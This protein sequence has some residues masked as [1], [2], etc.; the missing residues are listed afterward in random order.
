MKIKNILLL[1]SL[2]LL[3]SCKAYER[4]DILKKEDESTTVH[5]EKKQVLE[6]NAFT[7]KL[8]KQ[9]SSNLPSQQNMM[10][11]PFSISMALSMVSNGSDGETLKAFKNTLAFN[12]IPENDINAHH[13]GLLK[14]IVKSDDVA[15]LNIA[16]SIWLNNQFSPLPSFIRTNIDYYNATIANLNFSDPT[17]KDAINNWVKRQTNNKIPV[18]LSEL[19]THNVMYLI[20]AVY[21][22]SDWKFKFDLAFTKNAAFTISENNQ[23]SVPFMKGQGEFKTASNELVDAYE[24]PFKADRFSMII[25]LPKT[26]QSV[27]SVMDKLS[28]SQLVALN[29]GLKN[30]NGLLFIPKFKFSY[31]ADLVKNLKELGL[32][33]AFTDVANFSR[34]TPIIGLKLNEVKHKTNIEIT[35]NGSEAAAA[36]AVGVGITGVSEAAPTYINKPFIFVIKENKTGLILFSG[37]VNNPN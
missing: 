30:F 5:Y 20:N 19:D 35:E 21:F 3:I 11:S 1:L 31:D 18:I 36:T 23:V 32:A 14:D 6:N 7:F 12:G 34:I 33:S 28:L 27:S 8:F 9:M 16:N 15:K 10:I 25:L 2:G 24:L 37:I 26:S 13:E 17:A 29:K 4:E 22:K